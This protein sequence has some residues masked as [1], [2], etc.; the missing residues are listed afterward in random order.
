MSPDAADSRADRL[1]DFYGLHAPQEEQQGQQHDES[2]AHHA[3]AA[4]ET[5]QRAPQLT[6]AE[7]AA[8]RP[9][10]EIVRLAT[11]LSDEIRELN[12]DLQSLVYNHHQELVA[13][14]ETVGQMRAG[15]DEL[16]ESRNS[17]GSSFAAI[18]EL[19]G[20]L[21]AIPERSQSDTEWSDVYPVV[22][23][24]ATLAE[25]AEKKKGEELES[26][27]HTFRPVLEAWDA[28][29]VRGASDILNSCRT[30]IDTSA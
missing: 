17:L 16:N 11:S 4:A 29:G 21:D 30:V 20:S 18:E 6:F 25:L 13:V 8:T 2:I 5:T 1:R 10:S 26:T 22:A 7:L 27:W 28:S 14:A 3:P 19:R 15:I 24:P 12:G 9:L 23:L